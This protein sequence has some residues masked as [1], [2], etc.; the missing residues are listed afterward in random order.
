MVLVV[1]YKTHD[2]WMD[3]CLCV[4]IF[5]PHFSSINLKITIKKMQIKFM[6]K[7]LVIH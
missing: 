1:A 2:P 6:E 5:C 3:W 7:K 4:H